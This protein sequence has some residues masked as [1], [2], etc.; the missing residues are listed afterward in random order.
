MK[1]IFLII[2]V[3]TLSAAPTFTWAAEDVYQ[4]PNDFVAESIGDTPSKQLNIS[5]D[6]QTKV[7]K[8]MGSYY[9]L[10]K[11]EYWQKDGKTVWILD[12]IGKYEPI[13]AGFVV[14]PEGTL[15][16][17]KVLIYRESH[18]WEVKHKFFTN[19]FKGAGLKKNIT[20]FRYPQSDRP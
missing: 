14:T 2:F 4:S 20:P 1:R 13:T 6:L 15:E 19:Q 7:T 12:A 17:V 9:K 10:P 16:R 11:T 5:G 18:G 8:I 3:I